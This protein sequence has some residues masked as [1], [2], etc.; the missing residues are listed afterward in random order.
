MLKNKNK[1]TNN[2]KTQTL[3]TVLHPPPLPSCP[4]TTSGAFSLT[5]KKSL[6]G[7]SKAFSPAAES[8]P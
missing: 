5:Q 7:C 2:T 8:I 1:K 4:S 3:F 6:T